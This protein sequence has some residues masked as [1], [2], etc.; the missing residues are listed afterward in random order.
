MSDTV[1]GKEEKRKRDKSDE[2]LEDKKR[3]KIVKTLST[4][5]SDR[6]DWNIQ[7]QDSVAEKILQELQNGVERRPSNPRTRSG[8]ERRTRES[9]PEREPEKER[10]NSNAEREVGTDADA[11]DGTT[12][13]GKNLRE[14][15]PAGAT[16]GEGARNMSDDQDTN[17]S[18]ANASDAEAPPAWMVAF[19]K[20]MKED[21]ARTRNELKHD[22]QEDRKVNSRQLERLNHNVQKQTERFI[23]LENE[24]REFGRILQKC[25]ER[26]ARQETDTRNMAHRMD[27][28]EKRLTNNRAEQEV[29]RHKESYDAA[30]RSRQVMLKFITVRPFQQTPEN[31]KEMWEADKKSTIDYLQKGMLSLKDHLGDT[32]TKVKIGPSGTLE[33]A[34]RYCIRLGRGENN[35]MM[36]VTFNSQR[37]RD[38]ILS[39]YRDQY[40]D[41]YRAEIDAYHKERKKAA[42]DGKDAP[43]EYTLRYIFVMEEC[44]SEEVRSTLNK[45]REDLRKINEM[46]DEREE[47][48]FS[49]DVRGLKIVRYVDKVREKDHKTHWRIVRLMEEYGKCYANKGGYNPT[50]RKARSPLSLVMSSPNREELGT[51]SKR[52]RSNPTSPIYFASGFH[53][54]ERQNQYQN[55]YPGP[56]ANYPSTGYG[57]DQLTWG[58]AAAGP[59][60]RGRDMD[61]PS[62][63]NRPTAFENDMARF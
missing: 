6:K 32:A 29:G 60:M 38:L 28:M 11:S 31:K 53:D 63:D 18:E 57:D 4:L 27:Q 21:N 34:I 19:M 61:S 7:H 22:L 54:R 16:G 41:K 13:G 3:Q 23:K 48:K 50:K 10:A 49:L 52:P 9:N 36:K 30:I 14:E 8:T 20:Q 44:H 42:R 33:S 51:R 55:Q 37:D 62:Y 26:Q 12:G 45:L 25:G 40:E 24:Q 15:D 2:G 46:V 17:M 58:H 43:E 5:L 56:S 59:R 35:K 39:I 1:D 47:P